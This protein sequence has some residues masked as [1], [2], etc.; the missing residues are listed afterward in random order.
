MKRASGNYVALSE[1][2]GEAIGWEMG[3]NYKE[4]FYWSQH[5]SSELKKIIPEAERTVDC[6]SAF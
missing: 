2:C 6:A 3:Y 5:H 1:V 4:Q